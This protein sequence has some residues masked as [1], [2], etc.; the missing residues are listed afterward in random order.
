MGN[1]RIA[2][3]PSRLQRSAAYA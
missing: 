2:T 1:L 3:I